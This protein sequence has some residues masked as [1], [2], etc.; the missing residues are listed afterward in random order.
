MH[1]WNPK[2]SVVEYGI[3][4]CEERGTGLPRT[5]QKRTNLPRRLDR[6]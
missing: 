4:V 5:I 2:R 6:R 3:G 1:G